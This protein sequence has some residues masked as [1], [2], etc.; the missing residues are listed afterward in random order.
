M[1]KITMHTSKT[2]DIL[3][4][5]GLLA[6]AAK[7]I[8]EVLPPGAA[9]DKTPA[10][11]CCIVCDNTVSRLYGQ[12]SQPLWKGLAEAGY[13]V[14]SCTFKPGEESKTIETAAAICQCMAD[15]HF[16]RNDF[17]VA[18]GGGVCGDLAGFAAS[19]YMRGV[20]YVQIPTTLLA[21]ADSSIGGKTG[22][23][24]KAGKNMIGTFRQPELV[25]IDPAA[26]ETLNETQLLNGLAEILKAGFLADGTIFDTI[27]EGLPAAALKAIQVKKEIVEAD[28]REGGRRRLLNFGHTIGHAIEKCS[29]YKVPHG[30]A[31]IN[32]MYLTA[33][34]AEDLKWNSKPVSGMIKSVID[35][36]AYPVF[37]DYS[38]A[39][40]AGIAADDK[41]HQSDH[42]VIVY[43]DTPGHCD[44]KELPISKLE[45]FIARGLAKA[46]AA[47]AD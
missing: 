13:E 2:Y 8:A 15:H 4:D 3:M 18:L 27:S 29:G 25:L 35:A 1:E 19:I 17:V 12:Q 45:D 44:M 20:P 7:H 38:A 30:Y 40:L 33:L 31:V 24:T 10:L 39:E 46:T 26:L 21:M 34:A 6:F 42:I 37:T 23:N 14:C 36:F 47:S 41:K 5:E 11:R 28:E 22:V 32:G 16:G 9:D 43:P